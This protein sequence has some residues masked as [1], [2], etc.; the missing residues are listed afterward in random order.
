ML[1]HALTH[2][3]LEQKAFNNVLQHARQHLGFYYVMNI[4]NESVPRNI[5]SP[6]DDNDV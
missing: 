4:K 1:K 5:P 3:T 2:L 6:V